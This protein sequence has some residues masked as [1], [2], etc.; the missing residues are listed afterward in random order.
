MD[1]KQLIEDLKNG[2]V[3]LSYSSLKEFAISPAAFIRYKLKERKET[4]AMAMGTA[5]HTLVF[6]RDQFLQRYLIAPEANAATKQGKEDLRQFYKRATGEDI[7]SFTVASLFESIKQQTGFKI[8]S[9]SDFE[10][11]QRRA[12][13]VLAN[14][15]ARYVLD[16]VGDVE[17]GISVAIDDVPFT[18]Y[19]DG[20][21]DGLIVDLKN[22]TDATTQKAA[23]T[24]YQMRYDWQAFIYSQAIK[25]KECFIIAVDGDLE[26]STHCLSKNDLD[27][28]EKQ[29]RYYI[30][31]FKRA[32]F[33][34]EFN[35]SVWDMSQEFYLINSNNENGINYL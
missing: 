28:A 29:V 1:K 25:A 18:G 15:A 16:R 33:E 32:C 4:P 11:A 5:V 3:S 14:K 24:I 12:D 34:S 7:E 35:E 2:F 8:L 9:Y 31:Q 6:E 26:V 13:A 21:G 19:V 27:N 30:S 17:Q 22:M 20:L 23:R 10:E